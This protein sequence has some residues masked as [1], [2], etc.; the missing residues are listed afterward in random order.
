MT[1]GGVCF[2]LGSA[3]AYMFSNPGSN[4]GTSVILDYL[5]Y[6]VGHGIGGLETLEEKKIVI[7][8]HFLVL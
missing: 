2:Y 8:H 1:G 6:E 4:Q 5:P 7:T 3:S